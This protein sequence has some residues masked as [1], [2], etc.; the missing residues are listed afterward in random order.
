MLVYANQMPAAT[1]DL[2]AWVT[3]VVEAIVFQ[4]VTTFAC[5]EIDGTAI[6]PKSTTMETILLSSPWALLPNLSPMANFEMIRMLCLDQN[7]A[8]SRTIIVFSICPGA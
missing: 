4:S 7:R 2:P 1:D 5:A 3:I 6:T 8:A